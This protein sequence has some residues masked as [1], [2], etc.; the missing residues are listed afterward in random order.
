[1]N[2]ESVFSKTWKEYRKNFRAILLLTLIF[3]G[4]PF[5]LGTITLYWLASGDASFFQALI[6]EEV[7]QVS[8]TVAGS[9]F[10]LGL[11]SI[12][13]Y[14]IYEAGLV[15]DSLKGKFDLMK[16]TN[17][18]KKN[19]WKLVWF[20]VVTV[21]FLILLFLLFIIPG[22]IFLI[23]WFLGIYVYFDSNK[24]VIQSLRTS[25]YMVKGNWWRMLGYSLILFLGLAIIGGV[26]SLIG[27]PAQ[28]MIK[29][30]T[31]PSIDMFFANVIM[32]GLVELIYTMISVPFVVLF[33]KNIYLELRGKSKTKKKGKKKKK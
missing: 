32:Q 8:G 31:E 4:I 26:I 10:L 22:I 25:F 3:I 27:Y 16:T 11:F 24:T 30:V 2:F 6:T 33:Y 18:G 21:F 1:M 12:I 17:S 23:Y 9:L 28:Q 14:V 20:M 15:K 19:F 13:L 29:D 5:V 7:E